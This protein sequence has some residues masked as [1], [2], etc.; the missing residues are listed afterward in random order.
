MKIKH[1]SQKG[2]GLTSTSTLEIA[3]FRERYT[4]ILINQIV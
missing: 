2:K 4:V 1:D 3:T